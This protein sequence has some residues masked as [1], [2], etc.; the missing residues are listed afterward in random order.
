MVSKNNL[1]LKQT[2]MADQT[3]HYGLR[4]LSVGVASVLLS[5]TLYLGVTAQADTLPTGDESQSPATSAVA[6][7]SSSSAGTLTIAQSAGSTAGTLTIAQ[8]AG[9]TADTQETTDS[10]A[11]QANSTATSQSSESAV[12]ASPVSESATNDQNTSASPVA[13]SA[14]QTAEP[15]VNNTPDT[16]VK[17]EHD[18]VTITSNKPQT[19]GTGIPGGTAKFKG[20]SE[21]DLNQTLTRTIT[22]N[23]PHEGVKTI[24]QTA[25][26]SR[27]ATVDMVD[28]SVKYGDWSTAEWP[29]YSVPTVDGY[30]PS[31]K[32]VEA[33]AVV[34]GDQDD[35]ATINYTADKQTAKIIYTDE[36]DNP[37]KTDTV[38]GVTDQTVDTNSTVPTGWKLVDGQTIPTTIKLGVA[39]PDTIVKVEHDYVT[40]TSNKPQTDGT[41][42]PGGT[43][44]FSG[45][46][47]DD[48]NRT[49]TRTI[50][51]NDPHEGVKTITQTAQIHRDA[52]VD[53]VDG[54]VVYGDWSTAEWPA[55]SVPAVDGYTPSQATVEAKTVVDG[56]Q[57]DVATINYTADKQTAKIVYVD[58]NGNP[59]KTDTVEGV[60]D[61]IVDANSTIPTG[62]KSV[63]GQTIPVTIKLGVNTPDAVVKV[64]HDHVMITSNNPQ[65]DGTDIPGGTTKFSGVADGDLN[66]TLIRTIIVKLPNGQTKALAQTVKISRDATVDMVDGSVVYGDWSTAE[67]SEYSVPTV[68]GYTPSQKTVEA[69]TVA[70]GDKDNAIT[71]NYRANRGTQTINYVD[72]NGNPVVKQT[73]HGNVVVKQIIHGKTD[74]E[75]AVNHD[76]LFGW[77]LEDGQTVPTTVKIKAVDEPITI[78]LKHGIVTVTPDAPK[79]EFDRMPDWTGKDYPA[80]VGYNDLNKT[81]T[82]TITF[83]LPDG[84]IKTVKQTTTFTRHATVDEVTDAV[85]YSNWSE[86]S[87]TFDVVD[88]PTFDGWT[89]SAKQITETTVTPDSKDERVTVTYTANPKTPAEKVNQ[90]DEVKSS[91]SAPTAGVK[92]TSTGT[93][94]NKA[95]EAE[96]NVKADSQTT[97]DS[98]AKTAELPQTGNEQ[99]GLQAAAGLALTGL[100][101]M[102]GLGRKKRKND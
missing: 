67:W 47:N 85:A 29:E 45:V 79:T 66:Q 84:Q 99:T 26:I 75:I 38:D 30:A 71:I 81:V 94:A 57:D 102:L 93:V 34:D 31:Q 9:S 40:I 96:N 58:E 5:T 23:D 73:L 56:D 101:A 33:K 1:H 83:E 91:E 6:D 7:S 10:T 39:T 62:W 17:V 25:K 50:T 13:S 8:S 24:T 41:N 42:I 78:K 49:L 43:A 100:A 28:G 52:M 69:K 59:V 64:E 90:T 60:T 36:N 82:R 70:N 98:Q 65:A 44:K 54:S 86:Q 55:Y 14:D 88:V 21:N 20:V 3:P 27:D 48:L 61:Q 68:D 15:A 76:K 72:E 35:V 12:S 19:D 16:V 53:M 63:D 95:V 74:Q 46:D 92:E 97:A 80:S 2:K 32:T 11:S 89:S 87:H 22:I 77:V 18:H 37:V 51:I 4:K